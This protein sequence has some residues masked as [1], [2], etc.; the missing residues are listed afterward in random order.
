MLYDAAVIGTGPAGLSAA[1]NLKIHNKNFIWIGTKNL[2][3]KIAK[4]E[5]VSNYP[6]FPSVSGA[7]LCDAFKAHAEAMGLGITE[8]MVTQI[9]DMGDRYALNLGADFCEAKAVILATGVAPRNTLPGEAE[10]VGRGVSYCATCDGALYRGKTIAVICANARFEHEVRYLAELAE[11]VY[12]LPGYKNPG[13]IAPN[14]ELVKARPAG[15]EGEKKPLRLT[16]SDG[17]ALAVDG[18]FILRDSV[19]L[20]ALL[21]GLAEEDGHIAVDRNMATNFRGVYAA[22][23]CTGR[24]YQFTKAVGEGNVAA[25]GVIEYLATLGGAPDNA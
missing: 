2:S 17:E 18:V 20:S 3:D 6:G 25:H 15:I 5:L 12:F 19:T 7:G 24:P 11:K 23:D 13:D 14:A 9:Y 16:L 8:A 1:L 22:G 21:P 4:A 10:R